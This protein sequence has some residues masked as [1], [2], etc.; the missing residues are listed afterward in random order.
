VKHDYIFP[1]SAGY[2]VDMGEGGLTATEAVYAWE[3]QRHSKS[4]REV[5]P[6][7]SP[8]ARLE[9]KGG[10]SGYGID[11]GKGVLTM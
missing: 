11:W 10:V 3:L 7:E 6:V 8:D 2:S 1:Y 9:V 4:V 5:Q